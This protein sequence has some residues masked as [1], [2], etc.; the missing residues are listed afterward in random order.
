[1]WIHVRR[2]RSL[3]LALTIL[4]LLGPPD[5]FKAHAKPINIVGFDATRSFRPVSDDYSSFIAGDAP[6]SPDGALYQS[7]NSSLLDPANFGAGG[8]VPFSINF[9]PDISDARGSAL[10]GVDVLIMS[11]V[12]RLGT[13]NSRDSDGNPVYDLSTDPTSA[14]SEEAA[15]IAAFVRR[16]GC[17]VI[18]ADT[19]ILGKF[20]I[21]QDG[22]RT[23]NDVLSALDGATGDAGRIL[24]E[25]DGEGP[26]GLGAGVFETGVG[27][28]AVL[29]GPFA[30]SS[31]IDPN[32][33]SSTYPADTFAA[34][35]HALMDPGAANVVV[36]TRNGNPILME[37]LPDTIISGSGKNGPVLISTDTL[38]NDTLS[39]PTTVSVNGF[40]NGSDNNIRILMNFIGYNANLHQPTRPP[41]NTIPEPNTALLAILG[42][43]A[44]AWRGVHRE[45]S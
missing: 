38:F 2:A 20:P 35:Y 39:T 32:D 41:G 19:A 4:H 3:L 42:I 30:Y 5:G 21:E 28:S 17:L 24:I 1:M 33:D 44:L 13:T 14:A 26:Q 10:D 29:D 18:I 7:L 23:A 9:L 22:Q 11:E 36:G 37:I 27:T 12:R 15:A 34:S 45:R 8:I 16:G 6:L 40:E 31:Q 25:L 43:M